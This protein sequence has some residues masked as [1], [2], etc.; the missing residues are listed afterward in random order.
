MSQEAKLEILHADEFVARLWRQISS[1]A[2]TYGIP[3]HTHV[4]ELIRDNQIRANISG[5][6]SST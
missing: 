1:E 6:Q 3:T 4:P 2:A 5:A